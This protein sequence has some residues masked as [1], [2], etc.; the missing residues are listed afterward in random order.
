MN[1][2]I[3]LT[4]SLIRKFEVYAYDDEELGSDLDSEW[5]EDYLDDDYDTD[6]SQYDND[7]YENPDSEYQDE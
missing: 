1:A 5:N 3:C 4:P 6:Y 2:D 7:D